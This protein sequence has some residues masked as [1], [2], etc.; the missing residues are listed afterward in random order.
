M[1]DKPAVAVIGL[2]A[3][4]AATLYHLARSGVR[5]LGIDR[6]S[7]PHE[8]GSSHG[9]TRITR[10][11]VGEGAAYMPLV[12]RSHELW[13]ELEAETGADIMIT[14]GG[15]MI[16]SADGAPMHGV[17]GFVSATAALAASHDIEHELLEPAEARR[18]FPEFA[19]P[20]DAEIYYEPASGYLRPEAA[21]AAQLDGARRHGATVV[22]GA[23]VRSIEGASGGGVTIVTDDHSYTVDRCVV[24]A[25][26]WV[27]DFLPRRCQASFAIT[28]QVLHW[29]PVTPGSYGLPG[30]PIYIWCF[31]PDAGDAFYGFPS[32]DDR[33]IKVATETQGDIGH[34]DA[35]EREVSAAEQHRFHDHITA[36]RLR[37]V[38][39]PPERSTVCQYTETPVG[40]FIV[41]RHPE[42][43]AVLI[44]SCCS[45]HG[46]KHSAAL[47]EALAEALRTDSEPDVLK[48]FASPW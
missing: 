43:A 5:A 2:G 13:R 34:P 30:T 48:P 42:N 19:V 16:G 39:G 3:I 45:G 20:D 36:G 14:T 12:R 28:R 24:A 18:R 33:C 47:G 25:G 22:T 1:A 31:G 38:L 32:L 26:A 27:K 8:F 11:A 7:P 37:E 9:E 6:Y 15:I 10:L 4:G 17:S 29:L 35:I 41:D 44:A 40:Q 46:F 21:V 23:V